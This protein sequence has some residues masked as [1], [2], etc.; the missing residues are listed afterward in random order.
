VSRYPPAKFVGSPNFGYP[1][2]RHGQ[3]VKPEAFTYHIAQGTL[4]GTDAWFRNP[5]SQASAHFEVGKAAEVHQYVELT[6][7]PYTNGK[8][9]KPD[10]TIPWLKAC[11]GAGTAA[12]PDVNPNTVTVSIEHE[13]LTGVKWPEAQYQASLALTVWLLDYYDLWAYV[14]DFDNRFIGHYRIDSVDRPRCPGTGWPKTR[15][16]ADLLAMKE[17]E[18]TMTKE[19]LVALL[20]LALRNDT[21]GIRQALLRDGG[22]DTAIDAAA[23]AH[24]KL[25][26]AA[27]GVPAKHKHGVKATLSGETEEA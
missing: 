13:G 22:I 19:D 11:V 20:G 12:N 18:V 17:D 25:P 14:D 3:L 4:V 5:A 21:G 10:L 27:S 7:A 8:L 26:H 15:L 6:D 16:K 2:G 24:A 23:A 9:Q 1:S